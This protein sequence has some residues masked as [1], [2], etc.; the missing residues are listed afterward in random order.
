MKEYT[1]RGRSPEHNCWVY[2]SLLQRNTGTFIETQLPDTDSP[3]EYVLV[4][5]LAET[6]GQC[7]GF[8]DLRGN[9]MF[10][11]DVV[12]FLSNESDGA[13]YLIKESKG[14]WVAANPQ[15]PDW[16]EFPIDFKLQIEDALYFALADVYILGNIHD[17]P[18]L[19]AAVEVSPA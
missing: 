11:G 15:S 2:G 10:E 5:V 9:W 1:F 8:H 19:L 6:V 18:H 7:T 14:C 16:D 17:H 13:I 12:C 4:A 3:D